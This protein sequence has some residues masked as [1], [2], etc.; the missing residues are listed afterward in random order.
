MKVASLTI[1]REHKL[2]VFT[3]GDDPA[4]MLALFVKLSGEGWRLDTAELS[5]VRESPAEPEPARKRARR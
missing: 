5:L 3:P 2:L 1:V 4:K